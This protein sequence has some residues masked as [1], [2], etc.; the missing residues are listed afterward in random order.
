MY[1]LFNFCRHL[2]TNFAEVVVPIEKPSEEE[3]AEIRT[4]PVTAEA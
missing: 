3:K 1:F 2:S 4:D